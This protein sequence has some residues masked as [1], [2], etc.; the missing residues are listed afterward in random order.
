MRRVG[1]VA[2]LLL[3]LTACGGD[4]FDPAAAVVNGDKIPV[5]D[6][7]ELLDDFVESDGYKELAAQGNGPA[8]Q[9]E[10]EQGRLT[11][12][13]RRAVLAPAAEE[14]GI[15]VTDE[16]VDQR[17][18][19][20]IDAEFQGQPE[21]LEEGLK[22]QGLTQSQ[23]RTIIYDQILNDVLRDE[24]TS[25]VVPAEEDV[26]AFWEDNR[27][28]FATT[29][30]Q[31]ILVE[32]RPTAQQVAAR[33]QAA[34]GADVDDLFAE[35]ARELSTD[36]ASARSGGDLGYQPAGSY[37]AP[38]E[39]AVQQLE[40]GEVSDPVNTEFGWHVIRVTGR[41]VE[42][43]RTVYDDIEAQLAGPAQDEAWTE[44]LRE[45][46]EEA[47]VEVNPRYGIFDDEQ[48]AVVDPDAEDIPAGEAPAPESS[49]SA[50][51]FPVPAPEPG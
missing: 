9:R 33:L 21:Q 47:D 34:R 14:R 2:V 19:E 18:D 25:D 32:D 22:E 44:F 35:L 41:R 16:D 31:H 49:P 37:V 4:L 7:Q 40:E 46:F 3:A 20:L 12:L 1:V 29:R 38:F 10:F 26:R 24:V 50:P 30:V 17:I 5:E 11:D 27:E 6:V 8:F 43:L 42:S 51:T 23:F 39:R 45:L 28:R 48:L 36:R 15:E 13:I